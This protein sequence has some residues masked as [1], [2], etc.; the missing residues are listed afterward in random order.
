VTSPAW[1]NGRLVDAD[2]PVLLT[3]D[4]GLTVGDG[5]FETAKIV[6]GQVF[7]VTRHL[8]RLRASATGLGLPEPDLD[9]IR[10][11]IAELLAAQ[12]PIAFGR[13]RI[14]VTGGTGPLGSERQAGS[15]TCVLQ[16]APQEPPPVTGAVVLAPWVRNE[17]SAVAGIK[18]TSYAENVVALAYAKARGATESL[19]ANTQGNLC[20]GTGSNVFVAVDGE[21]VTPPLSAGPLAGISRSLLL[22][23]A[24]GSDLAIREADLPVGVL[25]GAS[26]VLLTSSIRDVQPQH[27][28]T[29]RSL[30]QPGQLGDLGGRAVALFEERAAQDIDP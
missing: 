6:R 26:E 2:R 8:H 7:A 4:H 9:R 19:L 3:N 15:G 23:W 11:G 12:L 21:L 28:V 20:E 25:A 17:R 16:A 14:T 13:L 30:R 29:G 18:T 10:A 5:V 22:E 24:D 1:V 27:A